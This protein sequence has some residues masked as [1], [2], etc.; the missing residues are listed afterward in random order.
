MS[1]VR[2][3]CGAGLWAVGRWV[4][5]LSAALLLWGCEEEAVREVSWSADGRWLAFV[6]G[7][8]LYVARAS[9]ARALAAALLSEK[10]AEPH[11]AWSPT[12]P[13]LL[14]TSTA[15]GGWDVW[16]AR[17]SPQDG[18]KTEPVT[19][20]PAKDW[21]A[22]FAPDGRRVAF[23]SYR[24][25]QSDIWLKRLPG[26][27]PQPL[28]DDPA[29]EEAL[30]FGVDRALLY[31][32]RRT[33]GEVAQLRAVD[34]NSRAWAVVVEGLRGVSE[35]VASPRRHRVAVVSR[36]Q[37]SVYSLAPGPVRGF[38]R[39][40]P[41]RSW[42][43]LGV[44]RDVAWSWAGD[45]VLFADG[46]GQV[47]VVGFEGRRPAWDGKFAGRLPR[48]DPEGKRLAWVVEP[49][50]R[51]GTLPALLGRPPGEQPQEPAGAQ[52]LFVARPAAGHYQSVYTD[53]ATLLAAA[54][55]MAA[56]GDFEGEA[57]LLDAALGRRIAQ[58]SDPRLLTAY[59]FALARVGRIEEAM[60]LA[61]LR[62]EDNW[63]QAVLAL[64]YAEDYAAASRALA[65]SPEPWAEGLGRLLE[66]LT[67]ADRARLA[68]ALRWQLEGRRGPALRNYL[69][70]LRRPLSAPARSLL[71]LGVGRLYEGRG[72]LAAALRTYR[73]V[74]RRA[75][76]EVAA[77]EAIRR[78]G[79]A[80]EGLSLPGEALVL[81]RLATPY[82][83]TPTGEFGSYLNQVRVVLAG[84]SAEGRREALAVVSEA[85]VPAVA[86]GSAGPDEVLGAVWVLDLYGEHGAANAVLAALFSHQ[87]VS[88]TTLLGMVSAWVRWLPA[89]LV[90][91][92]RPEAMPGWLLERLELV[93]SGLG[94]ERRR[95]LEGVLGLVSGS[96]GAEA[97]RGAGSSGPGGAGGPQERRWARLAL[98]Y[99][100]GN[101]ALTSDRVEEAIGTFTALLQEAG[102]AADAA[103]LRAL[104]AV[105]AT[106]P[107]VA[108]DWLL[109]L[110]ESRSFL[111]SE[112]TELMGEVA[113]LA[114]P[115]ELPAL[116]GFA[117]RLPAPPRLREPGLRQR[118]RVLER[119]LETHPRWPL[120][121]AAE[122]HLARLA[123]ARQRAQALNRFLRK[124]PESVY[125][126]EARDLLVNR[127]EKTGN[128]W[129]ATRWLEE[130]LEVRPRA[131]VSLLLQI[132]SLYGGP[133]GRAQEAVRWARRA[134][135]EARGT[136][137]WP[138]TQW[139]LVETL[140]EAGLWA[141][142]ARA[143]EELIRAAR[144]SPRVQSG[145][146]LLV[147]ARALEQAGDWP[148][149]E[150][151]YLEFA[152]KT[153]Q[154]RRL[155]DGR[156]LARIVPRM[157]LSTLRR[158]Y[159]SQPGL[160]R[161][162]LPELSRNQQE[163][164]LRLIPEL[165]SPP[166]GP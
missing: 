31:Y 69:R 70:L 143:V 162:A 41:T 20:H 7:E 28:T 85:L 3:R 88:E 90:L 87:A 132:A 124:Y 58:E 16:R 94:G 108:R 163:R 34:L 56:L 154:H 77:G 160:L 37:L 147:R 83:G 128:P 145:D 84:G 13:Q 51:T 133:L 67:A 166:S 1:V 111:W 38:R 142:Q 112:V 60:E 159:Q 136:E 165:T 80:A 102:R 156:L 66:E 64:A 24:G 18:W 121:D 36:G 98:L 138:P 140:G 12:A 53:Q 81:A 32:L 15:E 126:D 151:A 93:R 73:W 49:G 9:P 155:Q 68:Q 125:W 62:L 91:E 129:L 79:L 157:S 107:E 135:A 63:A 10:V 17:F 19:T 120:P 61:R 86:A 96:G 52:L 74:A 2:V 8:R 123:P 29:Q 71:A 130:L 57:A 104:R 161:S 76:G 55:Q 42:S 43:R 35:V 116:A 89:E 54:R 23:L 50:P 65:R 33:D 110:R 11:L 158:L 119:F 117:E 44:G 105:A 127:L 118:R 6:R 25:G 27:R 144:E 150:P 95:L 134:T 146:A 100:L 47:R 106:E 115:E 152:E 21:G 22:V 99:V 139:V 148:R 101:R 5:L 40:I 131:R 92:V 14:F 149:A 109:A 4:L 141:E 114:R 48:L 26:E 103:H 153:P 78:G 45:A 97:D 75:P 30:S 39:A 122:F 59:A 137:A 113:E 46:M 72:D 82:R 164:L